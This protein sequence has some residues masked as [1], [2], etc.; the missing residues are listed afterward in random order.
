MVFVQKNERWLFQIR[1]PFLVKSS[2]TPPIYED[3]LIPLERIS[4]WLNQWH[5]N[6]I[7]KCLFYWPSKWFELLF[8]RYSFSKLISI[9]S[10][11]MWRLQSLH[12]NMSIFQ[13]SPS[14]LVVVLSG[15]NGTHGYY[16]YVIPQL[17]IYI[18]QAVSKNV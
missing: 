4:F 12:F 15:D 1:I 7:N 10:N 14:T 16:S 11:K 9:T 8:W 6:T 18:N 3:N 17:C 5:Y 2:L 13:L